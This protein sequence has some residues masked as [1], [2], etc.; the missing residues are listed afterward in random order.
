MLAATEPTASGQRCLL[1]AQGM[2]S[3][4]GHQGWTHTEAG[5]CHQGGT[6]PAP[7]LASQCCP[8]KDPATPEQGAGYPRSLGRP[9]GPEGPMEAPASAQR[10]VQME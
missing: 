2:G 6:Q 9:Q 3:G 7:H 5:E 1:G 4:P 10:S 8:S